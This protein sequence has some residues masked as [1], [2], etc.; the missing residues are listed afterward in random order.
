MQCDIEF[1]QD[2]HK[3]QTHLRSRFVV[4]MLSS[5][6]GIRLTVDTQTVL[7][8]MLVAQASDGFEWDFCRRARLEQIRIYILF[9]ACRL[10]LLGFRHMA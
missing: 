5:E 7:R 8:A 3:D 6:G 4:F 1:G 10:Q 9:E 2:M